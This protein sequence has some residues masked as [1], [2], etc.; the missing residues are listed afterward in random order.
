MAHVHEED[1]ANTAVDLDRRDTIDEG[2]NK[3]KA[4]TG[5]AAD[6]Q[7]SDAASLVSIGPDGSDVEV[8]RSRLIEVIYQRF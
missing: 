3:V 4:A 7:V 5:N 6:V 2:R 1:A 8:L